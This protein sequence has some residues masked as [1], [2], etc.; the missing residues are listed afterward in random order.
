[1]AGVSEVTHCPIP[2]SMEFSWQDYWS[3]FPFLSPGDLLNPAIK[4]GY[5][6][7]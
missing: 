4:P 5:A 2:L 1:M 7:L 3:G 6:A